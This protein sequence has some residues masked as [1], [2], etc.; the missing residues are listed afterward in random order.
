[1]EILENENNNLYTKIINNI[2]LGQNLIDNLSK[3]KKKDVNIDYF[4]NHIKTLNQIFDKEVTKREKFELSQEKLD[5]ETN[6]SYKN[7][8]HHI[9][10]YCLKP[11]KFYSN[12]FILKK[13]GFHFKITKLESKA[14]DLFSIIYF[15]DKIVGYIVISKKV[16]GEYK[17]LY[18]VLNHYPHTKIFLKDIHD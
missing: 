1:M 18:L 6:L 16:N 14:Y 7:K 4:L 5:I 10:P 17:N 3:I 9:E 13:F 15:Q 11:I 2:N 12:I 8:Y